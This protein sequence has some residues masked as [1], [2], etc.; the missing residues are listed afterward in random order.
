M[1][2]EVLVFVSEGY[3]DWEI[4]YICAELNS[5][6][7]EYNVKTIAI[8]KDIVTSIGGLRV[9]PD[10]SIDDYP[11]EYCLLILTG[12]FAWSK[13][14]NDGILPLVK[15]TVNNNIPLGAICDAA[16]F[17]AK[18]GFLN[19]IKHTGNTLEYLKAKAPMYKGEKLFIEKQAVCDSNIVTVN[20][21]A[22]LEF[23]RELQLLLN[24]KPKEEIESDYSMYK[25]GYY[26]N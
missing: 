4:A 3:A 12:G 14:E 11:K 18:N 5:K 26:K 21:S 24:V 6:S 19:D 10:Y 1:K 15:D 13:N 23:S 9:V 16:T 2:N 8:T 7:P 25:K 17:L 20:G 22:G